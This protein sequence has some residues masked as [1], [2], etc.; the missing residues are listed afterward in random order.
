MKRFGFWILESVAATI[1]LVLC[2]GAPGVLG[3]PGWTVALS[4]FPIWLY[5][6]WRLDRPAVNWRLAVGFA[7]L[8]AALF[9]LEFLVAPER[10]RPVARI[11]ILAFAVTLAV[12]QRRRKGSSHAEQAQ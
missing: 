6:T 11:S 8:L 1:I 7:A 10:W 3:L 9:A 2:L 5:L 4:V 12:S